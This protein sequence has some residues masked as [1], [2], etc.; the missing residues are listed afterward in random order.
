MFG[1]QCV[2]E[3]KYKVCDSKIVVCENKRK[4]LGENDSNKELSVY[5]VDGGILKE[6]AN[7]KACDY[8]ICMYDTN[9]LTLI[10]LKGSDLDHAIKQIIDTVKRLKASKQIDSVQCIHSRIICKTSGR[11]LSKAPRTI[12]KEHDQLII[13]QCKGTIKIGTN[14]ILIEK[15]S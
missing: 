1:N 10:E 6:E 11:R 15:L 2:H 14:G 12:Q 3:K 8:L 4:Y 7:K 9:S 5:R 13:K